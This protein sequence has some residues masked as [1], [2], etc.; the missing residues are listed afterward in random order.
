[1]TTS[2]TGPGRPQDMAVHQR[3]IDATLK[4]IGDGGIGN[5]TFEEVAKNAGTTRPTIYRH[6][7]SKDEL[8]AEV[9][10]SKRPYFAPPDTGSFRSDIHEATRLFLMTYSALATKQVVLELL[11]ARSA[12]SSVGKVWMA[13]YGKPREDAFSVIFTRA[14]ER[15]ELPSD[16]E[17]RTLMFILSASLLQ[18]CILSDNDSFAALQTQADAIVS[19]LLKE[20]WAK[21]N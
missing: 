21:P 19:L 17:V 20:L 8:I 11:K 12:N 13:K 7:A 3:V 6:W 9:L 10:E 14:I 5:V 15:G 18:L 4:L 2:Q 16:L 1:M